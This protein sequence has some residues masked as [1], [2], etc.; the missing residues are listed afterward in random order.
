MACPYGQP[1]TT[2]EPSK[3]TQLGYR[4]FCCQTCTR[5]FNEPTGTHCNNLEFSSDI[6][7]LAV[8]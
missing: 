8:L 6:V 2:S 4:T 5:R 7:L 3:K 1:T